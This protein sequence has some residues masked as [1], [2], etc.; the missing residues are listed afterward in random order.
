M[1]HP[2]RRRTSTIVD[3]D[4][5]ADFRRNV[6]NGAPFGSNGSGKRKS[7]GPIWLDPYRALHTLF[8]PHKD[9]QLIAAPDMVALRSFRGR[10]SGA[11]RRLRRCWRTYQRC[12][13]K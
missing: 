4:A 12:G 6:G 8:A 1:R 13:A 10:A 5:L 9:V 2:R 3:G 7:K 11:S